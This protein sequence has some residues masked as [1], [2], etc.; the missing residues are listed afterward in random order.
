MRREQFKGCT[1]TVNG[2]PAEYDAETG[3][4]K[5]K[6]AI[7]SL[8]YNVEHHGGRWSVAHRNAKGLQQAWHVDGKDIVFT[9]PE[10][11]VQE[12]LAIP[13]TSSREAHEL[14]AEVERWKSKHT[15]L[16]EQLARRSWVR[17]PDR[18]PQREGADDKEQVYVLTKAGV[19]QM[20]WCKVITGGYEFWMT[21]IPAPEEKRNEALYREF[22]EV[23]A[24]SKMDPSDEMW[25]LFLK[26]N[27]QARAEVGLKP[28]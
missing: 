18:A 3:V 19:T 25:G 7:G 15:A 24:A 13:T 20:H 1:V 4:V 22:Q 17:T 9:F 23:C 6:R 8:D 16:E 27:A 10:R 11:Q 26:F 28:E 14:Y 5:W 12:S 2:S 21:P